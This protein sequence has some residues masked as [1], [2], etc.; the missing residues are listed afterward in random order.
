MTERDGAQQVAV[1]CEYAVERGQVQD[2]YTPPD[3]S[4]CNTHFI[5]S[6][7]LSRLEVILH[8]RWS[9]HPCVFRSDYH[10]RPPR[11]T[12]DAIEKLWETDD[13]VVASKP[14]YSRCTGMLMLQSACVRIFVVSFLEKGDSLLCQWL[15]L[16]YIQVERTN[17]DAWITNPSPGAGCT[18]MC[19]SGM[20]PL[21]V[22]SV[23]QRGLFADQHAVKL[24][25]AGHKNFET[26]LHVSLVRETFENYRDGAS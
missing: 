5:L 3:F 25:L 20:N 1:P 12:S 21:T 15:R 4:C 23:V 8:Y 11:I 19:S 17:A 2:L 13:S 18:E 14:T 22:R 26:K 10:C 9:Y 24:N 7:K 6:F 16:P